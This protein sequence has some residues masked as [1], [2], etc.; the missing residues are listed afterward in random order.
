MSSVSGLR[1]RKRHRP[2]LPLVP[3]IDVLVMLVLFAFVAMRFSTNTTLNI[4]LP[5]AET[6]G[7]NEFKGNV[8]VEISKDGKFS[9]NGKEA[10]E[11]QLV[12]L[13]KNV[14]QIDKDI[15][16]LVSADEKATWDK[17]TFA[18]DTCRK[19]GLTK[20]SMQTRQ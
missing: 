10:S 15:P 19:V 4:T 17:I 18:M 8:V 6:A 13:L 11:A 3:L 5:K 9:F 14:K 12:D 7:K 20:F 1:S 2:E 16:V